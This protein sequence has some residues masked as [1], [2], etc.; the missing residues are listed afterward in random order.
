MRETATRVLRLYALAL[1]LVNAKAEPA[2]AQRF[3]DGDSGSAFKKLSF[4]NLRKLSL[5]GGNGNY[6]LN[7][8]KLRGVSSESV[9]IA[10]VDQSYKVR[11]TFFKTVLISKSRP[12]NASNQ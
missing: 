12:V 4:G 3:P 11:S 10:T 8:V 1:L 9:E 6:T 5:K 2:A 7:G